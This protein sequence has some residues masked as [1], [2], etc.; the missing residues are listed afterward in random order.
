MT[1]LFGSLE[2]AIYGEPGK[3]EKVSG[4]QDD[5]LVGGLKTAVFGVLKHQD[6]NGHGFSECVVVSG[7]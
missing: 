2:T 3:I 7:R 1:D 5:D 4:S 6:P